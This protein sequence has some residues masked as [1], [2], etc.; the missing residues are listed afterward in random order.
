MCNE[1]SLSCAICAR[2]D[3]EIAIWNMCDDKAIPSLDAVHISQGV[4]HFWLYWAMCRQ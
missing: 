2:L 1:R 3:A 4:I